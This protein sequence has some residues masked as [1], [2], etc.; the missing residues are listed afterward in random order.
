[1]ARQLEKHESEIGEAITIRLT[2][3]SPNTF[4][5]IIL[6]DVSISRC[7][8][9]RLCRQ[10]Q[11]H[12]PTDML[13]LAHLQFSMIFETR[14]SIFTGVNVEMITRKAQPNRYSNVSMHAASLLLVVKFKEY[15]LTFFSVRYGNFVF[16]SASVILFSVFFVN[17]SPNASCIIHV[18]WRASSL[19]SNTNAAIQTN[20]IALKC[21][22]TPKWM[23][24]S[25]FKAL[26][27]HEQHRYI[28]IY[29]LSNKTWIFI[30]NSFIVASGCSVWAA[31]GRHSCFSSTW[32]W[33][34]MS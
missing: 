20:I 2:Y 17:D 24:Y 4:L 11:R 8:L 1:M 6:L 16:V 28:Y 15:P 13:T 32:K 23:R 3:N 26:L 10:H 12:W 9:A 34:F 33:K 7:V 5:F 22:D 30:F 14:K 19:L 29:S 27:S 25:W 18:R 31:I 21:N